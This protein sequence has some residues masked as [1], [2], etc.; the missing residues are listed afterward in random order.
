MYGEIHEWSAERAEQKAGSIYDTLLQIFEM[1]KAE[2][3]DTNAA[4]TRV[5]EQRIG[6]ARHLQRTW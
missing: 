6:Q 4:A 2:G 5:A 3:L 1:A